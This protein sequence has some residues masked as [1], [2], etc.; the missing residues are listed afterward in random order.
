MLPNVWDAASARIV[1][2]AG[3]PAIATSSAGIAYSLGYADGQ[4]VSPAEMFAAVARITRTVRVPVTADLEAGYGDP[5]A[6]A[7]AL[8][9]AGAV[10]LNFEDYENEALVPD[11]EQVRRIAA[12]RAVGERAGVHV[13]INART[14]I[15][16]AQIGAPETRLERTVA[17][18][19][20]YVAAGADCVFVPAVKDEPTI[21]ELVEAV[22]APVNIL[23]MPGSPS[24][25]RM[26][27][28]GVARV[29]TGSGPMRSSMA[30]MRRIATE[31]LTTGTYENLTRD[32]N[33]ADANALFLR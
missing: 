5:A 26:K 19:R 11:D 27:E 15:Y 7:Q 17:R 33:Y 14:D 22:H 4:L 18:L 20:R 8:L 21:R 12:I 1:E 30:L 23:A 10:G 9:D 6:T 32:L 2:Q 24:I 16:L 25:A 29:S 13:G 31:L 3:Y 28:L